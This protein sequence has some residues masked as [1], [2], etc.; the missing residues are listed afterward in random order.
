MCAC[1][2]VRANRFHWETKFCENGVHNNVC[3]FSNIRCRAE[4]APTFLPS[5]VICASCYGQLVAHPRISLVNFRERQ[6]L[7]IFGNVLPSIARFISLYGIAMP[8]KKE[9]GVEEE[10]DKRDFLI[11][12]EKINQVISN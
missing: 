10:D 3:Y 8:R 4:F 12:G 9:A 1:V 5:R 6:G 7:Y 2:F 11:N